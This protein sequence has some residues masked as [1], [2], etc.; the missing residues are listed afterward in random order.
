VQLSEIQRERDVKKTVLDQ[1]H[2]LGSEDQMRENAVGRMIMDCWATDWWPDDQ[3]EWSQRDL[4]TA[5]QMFAEAWADV[6]SLMSSKRP[7]AN[8]T[9]RFSS[10]ERS[11]DE[12]TEWR[13]RVTKRWTEI[14]N[15]VGSHQSLYRKAAEFVIL[16]N[17][18]P[19][20]VAPFWI[21][22]AMKMSLVNLAGH[23]LKGRRKAA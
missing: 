19:E 22:H 7:L 17:P 23:C 3:P 14:S 9:R 8:E 11:D 12:I 10:D 16:D 13:D 5:S 2:R 18:D 6:Q 15:A 4:Y 20:W 1:P 21:R